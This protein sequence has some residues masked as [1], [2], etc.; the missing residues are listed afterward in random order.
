M[1]GVSS[2]FSVVETMIEKDKFEG[3]VSLFFMRYRTKTDKSG[4]E[5]KIVKFASFYDAKID[6]DIQREL[7]NNFITSKDTF[8]GVDYDYMVNGEPTG[9][10][11]CTEVTKFSNVNAIFNSLEKRENV[12]DDLSTMN[13]NQIKTYVVKIN[14]S[15]NKVLYYFGKIQ[16]YSNLQRRG[17]VVKKEYNSSN[18]KKFDTTDTI[19]FDL[20]VPTIIYD[21]KIYISVINK[22]ESAFK[23]SEYYINEAEDV[24]KTIITSKK[25]SSKA[26]GGV[27]EMAK[28]DARIAKKVMKLKFRKDVVKAVYDNLS[29]EVYK[30]IMDDENIQGEYENVIFKDGTLSINDVNDPKQVHNFLNFIADTAKRGIASHLTSSEPF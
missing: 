5:P 11:G 30:E 29:E 25:I 1:S 22:F 10:V 28:K 12:L 17:L 23:M 26:L 19:G 7:L 2:I 15:N 6:T 24:I 8:E 13:L 20:N 18:L 9:G 4:N 14:L 21:N 16:N 27:N 3:N